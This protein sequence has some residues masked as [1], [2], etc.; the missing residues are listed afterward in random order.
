M[1]EPTFP[2]VM[3]NS[4][5]FVRSEWG[6]ARAV[7]QS[8]SPFTYSTQV[9]K[10]TGSKWYST[11]T[12]PPMKRSQANEWL[13]FFM[14]LNG[15]FGT[16]TMGDPDAKAVQGTISN[17]V[18]VNA[19]FAVGAYDVTIDGADASESQLF[20]KGDYVQFNSGATSKLHM[21]IADVASNGSGE[22]T[23][24]IEPSLSSALANNATVT[25]A[26]PKCV[27]RMTNNELTWS[28]NHISLYGVSF[29]CEEVL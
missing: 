9:H 14:Q 8:Q 26:S 22:A 2:L 6:I 10:F 13:A 27:M 20:K 15:Q 21:I 28:A 17:T 18:A 25:Y 11:V 4:P 19:D 24:T 3:P 16:F 12:L 7:A 29:S 23:L 5:N 1:A